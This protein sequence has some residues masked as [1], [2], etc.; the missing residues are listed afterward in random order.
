MMF[1]IRNT[2]SQVKAASQLGGEAIP[3]TALSCERNWAAHRQRN[4]EEQRKFSQLLPKK[5]KT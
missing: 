2:L 1:R 5:K 4:L 3:L